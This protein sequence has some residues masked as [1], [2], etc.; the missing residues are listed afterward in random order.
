MSNLNLPDVN[1]A[2]IDEAAAIGQDW[3]KLVN[4]EPNGLPILPPDGLTPAQRLAIAALV[5]GRTF[6]SAAI[7]AGVSRTTL[8]TWRKDPRF[9][10]AITD[11]SRE[12]LEAAATRARNLMLKA[13]HTI[14]EAIDSRERF[15][16]SM[17]VVN[18]RR[19]WTLGSIVPPE[20]PDDANVDATG[21]VN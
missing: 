3:S 15:D 20:L 13:M 2:A 11:L 5:N 17:R 1:V 10:Q 9:A 19:L 4:P 12:A 6:S 21:A 14:S 7:L 16:W 18:S 8:A